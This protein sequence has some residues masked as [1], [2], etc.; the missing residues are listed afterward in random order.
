MWGRSHCHTVSFGDGTTGA[1]AQ[2]SCIGVTAIVSGQGGIQ[3]SGSA[4]HTYTAAGSYA[5]TLLN[6]LGL[7]VGTLEIFVTGAAPNV[8]IALPHKATTVGSQ[9]IPAMQ[10]GPR[11]TVEAS[12]AGG[13]QAETDWPLRVDTIEMAWH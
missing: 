1:L 2:S 7:T 6:A 5:A 10:D 4:S 9:V 13:H 3:C 12:F 11:Q 8:S